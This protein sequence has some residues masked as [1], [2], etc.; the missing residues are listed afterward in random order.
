MAP[1][2]CRLKRKLP[3]WSSHLAYHQAPSLAAHDTDGKTPSKGWQDS[4]RAR[5]CLVMSTCW[6]GRPP[7]SL[8]L[9]RPRTGRRPH[10]SP[11][12]RGTRTWGL[13]AACRVCVST[14]LRP[15][16]GQVRWSVCKTGQNQESVEAMRAAGQ[17][18][19]EALLEYNTPLSCGYHC[20]TICSLARAF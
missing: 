3:A 2:H 13:G 14:H 18:G 11:C 7:H 16:E 8:V 12:F 9:Y 17:R 15:R 19:A 10:Q 4:D 1:G 6:G 20:P 5:H